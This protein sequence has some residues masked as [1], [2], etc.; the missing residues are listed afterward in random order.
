MLKIRLGQRGKKGQ[1]FYQI[2]VVDSHN[3]R[4]TKDYLAVLGYW[5]RNKKK[6]KFDIKEYE[7]WLS[8]G[9]QPTADIKRKYEKN[10]IIHTK[11]H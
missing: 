2:V 3:S 5:D 1:R 9:A 11:E 7:I 6:F 4:D 8:R 10:M